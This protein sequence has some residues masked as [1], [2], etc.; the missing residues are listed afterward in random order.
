M[1]DEIEFIKLSDLIEYVTDEKY[2]NFKKSL[3]ITSDACY[4]G[5]WCKEAKKL[6]E[7]EGSVQ[8]E[9]LHV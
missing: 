1:P 3:V 9:K 7:D 4:S 8:L 2:G 6:Y 5:N